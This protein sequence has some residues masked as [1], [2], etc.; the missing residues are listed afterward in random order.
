MILLI[1]FLATLAFGYFTWRY[2][3]VI[4][5]AQGPYRFAAFEGIAALVLLNY[6]VWFANVL[7]PLQLVS[8]A[9]LAISI[10][11]PL[12][13]VLTLKGRGAPEGHFEY[14]TKLVTTGVY[15]YIRHPM[16]ASLLFLAI[17]AY[18][19][20]PLDPSGV[21]IFA[22]TVAAVFMTARA[23]ERDLVAAF[24]ESYVAYM[25]TTA[26]FIPFVL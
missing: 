13:G 18:L 21:A 19:K 16:Y 17:G 26:R 11:L 9:A 23:E 2:A 22:V 24:G 15:R 1:Y 10:Y 14:T 25:R 6:G 12:A 5:R 8:F 4:P 20:R 3:I 7:S